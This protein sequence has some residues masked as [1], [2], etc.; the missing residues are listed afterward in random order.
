M[1]N[2]DLIVIGGGTAGLNV[3]R[4]ASARG[5][6][7]ALVEAKQLGGTC[8]NRGCIPTK[9]LIHSAKVMHQVKTA[10]HFG[11]QTGEPQADWPSMVARKDDVVRRMRDA[12]Y[13]SI[14]AN[15]HIAFYEGAA[16]FSGPQTLEVKRQHMTADRIVIATGAGPFIPPIPGLEETNYLTSTSVMELETLP[17]TLLIIGGGII[18]VEFSQML[19]RL[20]VNVTIVQRSDRLAPNLE[21]GISETLQKIL[22]KENIAVV[23]DAEVE[24]VIQKDDHIIIRATG[25]NDTSEEWTV[26]KVLV[27]TGRAP[28]TAT[29]NLEKANVST[30]ARG[31]IEVDHTFATSAPGI[32]AIG[33]VIGGAMFTHKAWHDG[34]LLARHLLDGAS[35]HSEE[36]LIPFG[37]FNDPEIAGVGLGFE[38]AKDQGYPVRIQTFPFENVGRA[39]AMGEREGF[40]QLVVE[41]ETD[42]ILGAHIIG[43]QAGEIIHELVM[44]MR[45]KATLHDLQDMMHIHPTLAESINSTGLATPD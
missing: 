7:V 28:N 10:R 34:V 2:Y 22:E 12:N 44:A 21:P 14:E 30:N 43:P 32:W 5:W 24:E 1:R 37:V 39:R 3:A 20:G 19:A 6:Q 13:R 42:T 9:T 17:E 27:A 15:D 11:I 16:S 41:E 29:L 31:Y 25:K 18:A 40:V 26:K 33:D 23:T 38:A 45:L 35:I 4:P 8:V 36:R